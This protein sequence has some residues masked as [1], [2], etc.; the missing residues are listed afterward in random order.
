MSDY[1][2]WIRMLP[3]GFDPTLASELEARIFDPMWLLARQ[4][5]FGE[6]RHDGG[7]NPVD[8]AVT[9]AV[10]QPSRMR[11]AT[12]ATTDLVEIRLGGSPLEAVQVPRTRS[13]HRDTPVKAP[14]PPE[15]R[16]FRGLHYLTLARTLLANREPSAA[17]KKPSLIKSGWAILTVNALPCR[18]L[19]TC[20]VTARAP[21]L[22][23]SLFTPALLGRKAGNA[24]LPSFSGG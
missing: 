11:A 5:Q 22:T 12:A 17:G 9:L 16:R 18:A 21:D 7:V 13:C 6:F 3:L 19:P 24:S 10:A 8:I 4:L 2:Q 23:L 20:H 15:G 1:Q 14:G